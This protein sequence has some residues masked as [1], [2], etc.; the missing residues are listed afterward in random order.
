MTK[1]YLSD[2]DENRV[3]RFLRDDPAYQQLAKDCLEL[4]KGK[5]LSSGVPLN[6]INGKYKE[7]L[8]LPSN[9]YIEAGQYDRFG[10][11]KKAIFNAWAEKQKA[12]YWQ[13]S[14]KDIVEKKF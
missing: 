11:L 1:A 13:K 14:F 2:T 4:M 9:K 8:G 12:G 6:V 5:R 3:R 7:Q 10:K